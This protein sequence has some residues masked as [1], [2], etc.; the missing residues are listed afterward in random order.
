MKREMAIVKW[1]FVR[2]RPEGVT[3]PSPSGEGWVALFLPLPTIVR[4]LYA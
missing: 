1:N 2:T 4:K 3:P